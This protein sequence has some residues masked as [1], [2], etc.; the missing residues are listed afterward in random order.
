MIVH[1]AKAKCKFLKLSCAV[2]VMF[3]NSVKEMHLS[4]K[5]KNEHSINLAPPFFFLVLLYISLD[6]IAYT[7]INIL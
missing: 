6:N 2:I 4:K 3:V 7:Y 5:E 1:R